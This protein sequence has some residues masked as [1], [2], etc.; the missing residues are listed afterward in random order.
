MSDVLLTDPASHEVHGEL[1]LILAHGYGATLS[2]WSQQV[3]PFSQKYKVVTYDTRATD[4]SAARL[5]N[6]Q[7]RRLCRGPARVDGPP[8]HRQ[9]VRRR[10]VDGRHDCDAFRAG[11]SGAIEGPAALRHGRE[12]PSTRRE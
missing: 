10:S 8:G 5:A 11:T 4:T 1:P 2:M 3:E 7:R 6:V 9:G 12:Q